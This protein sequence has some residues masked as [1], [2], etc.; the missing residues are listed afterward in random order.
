V[1]RRKCPLVEIRRRTLHELEKYM[2]IND[3]KD[4][5]SMSVTEVENRLT[6]LKERKEGED[7]TETRERLKVSSMRTGGSG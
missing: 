5:D 6:V 7:E 4:V 1:E 2:R 3:E